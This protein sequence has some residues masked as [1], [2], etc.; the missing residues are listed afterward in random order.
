MLAFLLLGCGGGDSSAPSAA[1]SFEDYSGLLPN[2]KIMAL[3]IDSLGKTAWSGALMVED[4][5]GE[6]EENLEGQVQGDTLTAQ[7]NDEGGSTFTFS[8]VRQP[9][10]SLLVS[11]SD[12][13]GGAVV[14]EPLMPRVA[15]TPNRGTMSFVLRR[16]EIANYTVTCSTT[17]VSSNSYQNRYE[18]S[19]GEH[20]VVVVESKLQQ[21]CNVFIY[22][23]GAGV[24]PYIDLYL[25]TTFANLPTDKSQPARY[26]TVYAK[27]LQFSGGAFKLNP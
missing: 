4:G 26:G 23:E 8:A 20:H 1:R 21:T 27:T 24:R 22:L 19:L 5:T 17:P 2:G 13:P 6:M 18:G 25:N 7:G 10:G 15:A 9:N 3:H 11:H 14:L 16:V 12:F